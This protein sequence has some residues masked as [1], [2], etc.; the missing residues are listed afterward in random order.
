M[1]ISF[2]FQSVEKS[3]SPMRFLSRLHWCKRWERPFVGIT[4]TAALV[5]S[6]IVDHY[7]WFHMPVCYQFMAYCWGGAYD[8]R[9]LTHRSKLTRRTL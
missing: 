6:L 1:D 8:R 5:K 7:G 3:G 9:Y 2:H 4:V